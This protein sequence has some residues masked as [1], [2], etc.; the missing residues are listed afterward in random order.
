[1]SKEP[2]VNP[3]IDVIFLS[4]IINKLSSQAVI[5]FPSGGIIG[6]RVHQDDVILNNK[7]KPSLWAKKYTTTDLKRLIKDDNPIKF[8]RMYQQY[9]DRNDRETT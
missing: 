1:M 9:P 7:S 2:K 5:N 8:Q 4:S 3:I 6:G